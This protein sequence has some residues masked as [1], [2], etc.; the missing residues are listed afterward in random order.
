MSVEEALGLLPS[1]KS[2][3]MPFQQQ[4]HLRHPLAVDG[5]QTSPL[6][7][8]VSI[9][10]ARWLGVGAFLIDL[11]FGYGP[12]CA[13]FWL[14]LFEFNPDA[15]EFAVIVDRGSELLAAM[16]GYL[17]VARFLLTLWRRWRAMRAGVGLVEDRPSDNGGDRVWSWLLE[18]EGLVI[19]LVGRPLE[20]AVALGL[21]VLGW[22]VLD[23]LGPQS[24]A[25]SVLVVFSTWTLALFIGPWVLGFRQAWEGN[26]QTLGR[27]LFGL[28][29]HDRAGRPAGFVRLLLRDGVCRPLTWLGAYAAFGLVLMAEFWLVL[30]IVVLAGGKMRLLLRPFAILWHAV[31]GGEDG[32]TL[33]D[34]LAGTRVQPRQA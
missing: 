15:Q 3:L 8:D 25:G 22:H 32:V 5:F 6:E 26:G 14:A 23:T 29:V 1:R 10:E 11:L 17:I 21:F 2:W 4:P 18:L 13:G 16:V 28:Q 27:S 7:A 24:D 31:A 9:A 34:L 33:H 19:R 30:P 20:A 12:T